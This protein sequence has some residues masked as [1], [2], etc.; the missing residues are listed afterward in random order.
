MAAHKSLWVW[1]LGVEAQREEDRQKF[2]T[3]PISQTAMSVA[4][5]GATH[6]VLES[7]AGNKAAHIHLL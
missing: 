6:A 2:G 3:E 5:A 4:V 1:M 7:A